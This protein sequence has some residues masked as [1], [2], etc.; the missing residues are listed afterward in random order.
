MFY[1]EKKDDLALIILITFLEC[2]S[3]FICNIFI[4]NSLLLILHYARD[5]D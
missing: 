4:Y 2:L 5:I 1:L 3:L